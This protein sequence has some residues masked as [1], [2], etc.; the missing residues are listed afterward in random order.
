MGNKNGDEVLFVSSIVSD[1]VE[2]SLNKLIADNIVDDNVNIDQL[3]A[4]NNVNSDQVA[5]YNVD[6]D[7][8]V[9]SNVNTN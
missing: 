5:A 2:S 9:D 7:R 8:V 1:V 6:I 3:V 4:K